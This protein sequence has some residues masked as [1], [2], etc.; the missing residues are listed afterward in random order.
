[1]NRW[2]RVLWLGVWLLLGATS[3]AARG[4]LGEIAYT[5]LPVQAQHTVALIVQGG[6]FPYPR[7]DGTVFGNREGRLPPQRRG[8][9][10]EYTVPTPGEPTRGA[11][12]II[13]GSDGAFYYTPDHY[14]SFRRI[15]ALPSRLP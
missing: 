13:A 2:F 7:K 9:Y 15:V 14:R 4:P 12:R 10:R 11:R 8:F 3:V 5:E 1:M 6:P